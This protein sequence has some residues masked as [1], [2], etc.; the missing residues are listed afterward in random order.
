MNQ[1]FKVAS[2]SRDNV[3]ES[4]FEARNCLLQHFFGN[5]P[6]FS[7]NRCLKIIK[8]FWGISIDTIFEITP[9]EKVTG[10]KIWRI[11]RITKIIFWKVKQLREGEKTLLN[12]SN[13]GSVRCG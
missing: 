8:T 7:S 11:W 5:F 6:N 2:L 3:S 1:I 12:K 13:T 9:K 10:I 4:C